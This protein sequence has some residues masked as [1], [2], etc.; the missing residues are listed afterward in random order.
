MNNALHS[1]NPKEKIKIPDIPILCVNTR[2][3]SLLTTDGEMCVLSHDS[4]QKLIHQQQIMLCHAP[5]TA[6]T[7]GLSH[8]SAPVFDI[9]ELFAFVHPAK[10]CVPTPTGLAKALGLSIPQDFESTPLSLMEVAS[11]LLSDLRQD[12][13][14]A[15]ANP[16]KIANSMGKQGQ[17][18]SGGWT[19]TPFILFYAGRRL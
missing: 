4:A 13:Y 15:K 12:P 10:F 5:Y 14:Q 17:V 6:K 9:L 18:K 19:W 16:L 11:A 2:Q 1:T 7:L 8:F 3:A